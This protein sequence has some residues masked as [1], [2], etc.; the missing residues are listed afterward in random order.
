MVGVGMSLNTNWPPYSNKS[1]RFHASSQGNRV[2][3]LKAL[4]GKS[5]A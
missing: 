2:S 4:A 1:D 3:K 5:A